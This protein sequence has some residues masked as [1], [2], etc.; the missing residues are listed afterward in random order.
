MKMN[1]AKIDEKFMKEALKEAKVS[2]KNGDWP[3]GSVLVLDGK[4]VARGYNEVYSTPSKL[5]H[6]EL[7]LLG[8]AQSILLEN[9]NQ[10]TLYT[11]SEP[12]PMCFGAIVLNRVKR[13]VFGIKEN[14]G[15]TSLKKHFPPTLK[16][17][18][19]DIEI[20]S[21]VLADECWDVFASGEPTQKL[22]KNDLILKEY[23]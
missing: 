16:Q 6:A 23:K 2:L 5:A 21:G 11:T 1:Q 7:L 3:I 18:H 9:R 17:G 10:C 4:I 13:L 14:S 19:Y 12:C 15:G 20:E 22:I 8:K